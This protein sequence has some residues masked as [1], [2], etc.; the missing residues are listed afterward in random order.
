METLSLWVLRR[1]L[2]PSFVVFHI[3]LHSLR[4]SHTSFQRNPLRGGNGPSERGRRR[5]L[6]APR[7]LR[8]SFISLVGV[9]I[10]SP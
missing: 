7:S 1:D 4:A 3:V 6:R 5:R 2:S 9:V 10:M 8:H